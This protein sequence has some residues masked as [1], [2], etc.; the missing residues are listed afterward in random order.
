[1]L[2]AGSVLI[3]P[4]QFGPTTR[5]PEARAFSTRR[6]SASRPSSPVSAKP[7]EMTTAALTPFA[8]Q[9]SITL[10]TSGAGTAITARSSGPSMSRS[11]A[12]HG[13]PSIS[14]TFGFTAYRAPVYRALLRFV[15]IVRPI[16]PGV[17]L[18]PTTAIDRG[19]KIDCIDAYAAFN[20]RSAARSP[21]SPVAAIGKETWIAP[22]DDRLFTSKPE[23]RKTSSILWFSESTSAVN[24]S[25][26]CVR[27][28]CASLCSRCV[29]MPHPCAR[30]AIANATSAT[31][32]LRRERK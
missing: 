6:R 2:K 24:S 30:S 11:E 16:W 5:I 19:S 22:S 32:G 1:M 28:T 8:T 17:R 27:A 25:I 7:A 9:S 10:S 26:S 23:Q 12:T 20:E 21:D 3:T 4:M 15:R 14:V 31:R 18:A 29:P 13:T